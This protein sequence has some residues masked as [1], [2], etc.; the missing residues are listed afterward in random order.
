MSW[1]ETIPYQDATGK[2]RVLYERMGAPQGQI[3]N[4]L[5]VHSLRPH[6][7]EGHMALYKAVLHHR[8]DQLPRWLLEAVGVYVSLLNGCAY[9]VDHH[10]AGLRRLL[11]DDARADALRGALEGEAF[12][13]EFDER[14]RAVLR[15]ARELTLDP[16]AVDESSVA[17]MRGAGF[18]DGEI[19]EI[20]QVVSYFAYANRT[21]LGLG[22]V[23]DGE[24]LG[25][26]PGAAEGAQD[27]RHS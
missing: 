22:V 21:V 3:D 23:T 17:A 10:H 9:C 27:W 16:G 18:G 13:E 25:L 5:A 4:I 15:Y 12:G 2:L 8:G 19:L 24:I 1:I 26:A 20:N 6:T 14:E 7:L 11:G